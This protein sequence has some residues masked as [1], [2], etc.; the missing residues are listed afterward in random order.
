ML[1]E[2]QLHK[3]QTAAVEHI[4]ENRHS[5]LFLEMGLGKTVSTLTAIKKLIYDF[6]EVSSVI[7]V[8]PK[9]VAETVWEEECAVWEHLSD[10]V[11]SKVIGNPKQRLK[12]LEKEADIYI[13]SRDNITWLVDEMGKTKPPFDMLVIDELSSFKN[14]RAKR[15]RAL[16]KIRPYFKWIVGLT[17][18]PA[19]NGLLDLWAQMYIID[20]GERLGSGITKYR[21]KFFTPGARNGAVVFNYNI[22]KGM[23]QV[24][25]ER[26]SDIC[27]SMKAEDYLQLPSRITNVI[28][29]DMPSSVY[30]KYKEFEREQIINISKEEELT[31]LNAAGLANKLL[32]FANGAVYTEERDVIEMHDVK[33][34]ALEEI[35]E[36]ANGQSVFIAYNFKHDLYRI[37]KRLKK[38]NPVELKGLEEVKA[39]NNGEIQVLIA[40]PASA[41]HGLNIQKGGHIIV[42]FGL[43]WSLELYQQ[44]NARL[45]RQGQKHN[46]IIHHLVTNSTI[47][48]RVMKV[49]NDKDAKQE[50]LMQ[51]I[52]AS[53]EDYFNVFAK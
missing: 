46:P 21:N 26:I 49:I 15:F 13:I 4:L 22:R 43:N 11:C 12:A 33:L 51:S 29:L 2:S 27:I 28:R 1:K 19:P 52:K 34:D 39:W 40:H 41:G 35:I 10:L 31:A 8:A 17:G 20:G 3:Y 44:F 7:V 50:D 6:Y 32:Q 48:E 36:G 42:W 38:Y 24:I 45:D 23:D 53:I 16:R 18:T 5:G 9:R 25:H 37:K 30:K 14:H 47:D